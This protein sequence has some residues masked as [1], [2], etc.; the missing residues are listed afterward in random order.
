MLSHGPNFMENPTEKT[1]AGPL[2]SGDLFGGFEF[3]RV[4]VTRAQGTELYMKVPK[5]WRPTGRNS[6]VL[7]KA[8]METTERSDW[9][10]Y[11]W[12]Q[13]VELQSCAVVA[14]KEARAYAIYEV[15]PEPSSPNAK[16][17]RGT[18]QP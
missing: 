14:E 6:R 3:L 9:D 10:G 17:S 18:A 16:G 12:E 13:T 15:T 11:G 8:A 5:G 7:G 4:E 2:C 1:Q